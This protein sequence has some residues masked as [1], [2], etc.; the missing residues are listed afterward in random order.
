M[1]SRLQLALN[2][3]DE[4]QKVRSAQSA[5]QHVTLGL[6]LNEHSWTVYSPPSLSLPLKRM[7][8]CIM[9]LCMYLCRFCKLKVCSLLLSQ[10]LPHPCLTHICMLQPVLSFLSP[11]PSTLLFR[12]SRNDNNNS[13]ANIEHAHH[14]FPAAPRTRRFTHCHIPTQLSQTRL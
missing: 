5:N 12:Y 6:C 2:T 13:C 11:F 7:P 14:T 3:R 10:T 1:P 8:A 4:T 9:H